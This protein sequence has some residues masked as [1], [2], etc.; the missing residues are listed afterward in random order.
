MGESKGTLSAY[1]IVA[2]ACAVLPI[3]ML[4]SYL[5][6]LARGAGVRRAALRHGVTLSPEARDEL[7]APGAMHAAAGTALARVT[8]GLITRFNVPAATVGSLEDGVSAWLTA[9]L[10]DRYFQTRT[11]PEGF[12][13]EVEEARAIRRAVAAASID[14]FTRLGV[15]A[16][17]GLGRTLQRLGQAIERSADDRRASERIVDSVLDA[18]ADVPEDVLAVF[19]AAFD[20]R[21]EVIRAWSGRNQTAS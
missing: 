16:P 4:D 8:R 12:V 1:G 3:P 11:V 20:A 14:G 9:T 6:R 5:G 18:V 2:G 17:R 19:V 13:L 15:D 21:T 7:A 10:L